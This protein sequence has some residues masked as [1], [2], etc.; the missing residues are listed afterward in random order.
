MSIIGLQ[1]VQGRIA[2]IEARF[3]SSA[4]PAVRGAADP[5]SFAATLDATSQPSAAT[6]PA[7][8]RDRLGVAAATIPAELARYAN[9]KIPAGALSPI[10]VGNH[11][12]ANAAATEFRKM[13][14][15]AETAGVNIGVTDSYRDLATQIDLVKRKGLYSQGGLA[16]TPGKSD[17]GW[18][19]ATDLAV[20]AKGL[21]WLRTNAKNYGFVEDVPREPWHWTFHQP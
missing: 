4:A 20:D 9:G 17:H 3:T 18:G 12:L 15:A 1:A 14:A 5:A 2:A 13:R 7:T 16:A 21:A 10:G 11:R 8:G 19:I 6:P